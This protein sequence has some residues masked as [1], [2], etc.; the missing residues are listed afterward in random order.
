[1]DVLARFWS[2]IRRSA[3]LSAALSFVFPGL[4]QGVT[5]AV[6][7]GALLAGPAVVLV[8][9]AAWLAGQSKVRVLGL[10]LDPAVVGALLVL[11]AVLLLYR[12]AAIVDAYLVSCR[13]HPANGTSRP[14]RVVSVGILVALL[15]ATVSM[16][17]AVGVMGYKTYVADAKFFD[18]AGP[19]GGEDEVPTAEPTVGPSLTVGPSPTPVRTPTPVPPWKADGRLN[20]LL[21]G[22]DAGP[23]RWSLRTDTMLL[24][25]VDVATARAAIFGIP[26]NL[27][28][29]PLGA[30]SATAFACGCFPDLLN[31]LYVYAGKHPELFPGGSARGYLALQAAVGALTGAQIDGMLVVDLNGFVRLVDALGGIDIN[32]PYAIYDSHYP[33][34]NGSGNVAI[35]IRAGQQHMS[36]HVALEY[37]R[38]RH[39]DDDYHRMQRQQLVLLAL[40]RAVKPCTLIPRLPELIDIAGDSLWTNLS[41]RD[42]P[43]LLALAQ[44]VNTSRVAR[45]AFVP[46]TIPE[47]LN[48]VAVGRVHAMVASAFSALATPLPGQSA[49]PIPTEPADS[50]C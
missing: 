27:I 28:N 42:M 33:L 31:A 46:P 44:R 24:L 5:G 6:V 1:M 39:Q 32:V 2:G 36:G 49:T 23:G 30:Q 25:S 17:A 50:D 22:G 18:P 13:L 43:D 9:G 7:R 20:L 40:R 41:P 11:D 10:F 37:A 38:S 35:S 14:R 48:A 47:Y 19:G 21:V 8:A 29:V 45:F 4:G 12:L 26:R 34:E 3:A 15:L 16:H